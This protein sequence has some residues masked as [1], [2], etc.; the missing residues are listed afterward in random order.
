M[1][2]Y[3]NHYPVVL[4]HGMFGY[5]QQ[6]KTEAHMPYFGLWNVHIRKLFEEQGIKTVA[7]SMGPFTGAWN[8]ACEVYAQLFGG[9][10]DYGKAHSEK[11]GCARYG[12]TYEALL[13]EWGTKDEDGNLIKINI[14]GHSFGGVTGRL[15][16]ELM[17]N[18]SAEERAVTDPGDLSPLFAGG[19]K[20]W[21]HSITTLASPHDGA[22]CAEGAIGKVMV[23][24]CVL[25]CDVTN[26][27]G[28]TPLR[29]YY[30]L[31]LDMYGFNPRLSKPSSLFRHKQ[32]K[33]YFSQPDSVTYDASLKGAPE[34][35]AK[36]PAQSNVYY[37][38]Y[39]GY[40]TFRLPFSKN[41]IPSPLAFPLINV[42]GFFMGRQKDGCPDPSWRRNDMVINTVS[43]EAPT[44][45]PRTDVPEA[46]VGTQ[47]E[48]GIWNVY[49]AQ[50]KDHMS[51]LGWTEKESDF[52]NFYQT[53]Y[54]IASTQPTVD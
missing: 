35:N 44:G 8:R 9:T 10:V 14:I 13:P 28:V 39:R 21:V 11:Y 40:R 53:I 18:G 4:L 54:D 38:S 1:A 26:L 3:R 25:I 30:D 42:L 20:G 49:P 34:L 17:V 37:F 23:A 27:I 46:K 41:E 43:G 12:R 47:Y 31:E 5:G 36:L 52:R 45:D 19:H 15:L 24:A 2:N 32:F 22:T 51:F 29:D 33:E 16:T 7:P 48:P 6:Q 50:F